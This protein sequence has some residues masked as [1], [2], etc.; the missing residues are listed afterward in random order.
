[1][2]LEVA[3]A[4]MLSCSAAQHS[5]PKASGF[6]C[7]YPAR[8]I[9]PGAGTYVLARVL[10]ARGQDEPE[11]TAVE[12]PARSAPEAIAAAARVRRVSVRTPAVAPVTVRKA[13]AAA[14]VAP[15]AVRKAAAA[16]ALAPKP[17][18]APVIVKAALAKPVAA[19][20]LATTAIVIPPRIP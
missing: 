13:A 8:R 18:A 20:P 14:A 1:M 17:A 6:C 5:K 4:K 19:P 9:W 3:Y 16:A 15:I 11:R 12:H 7:P 2:P 10:S